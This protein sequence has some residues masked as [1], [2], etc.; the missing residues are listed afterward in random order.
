MQGYAMNVEKILQEV[1][2]NLN[3]V[4]QR[5]TPLGI[6]LWNTLLELHPADLADFFADIA[7]DQAH[8]LFADLPK[9]I[10]LEVFQEASDNL[11]TYFLSIMSDHEQ[12]DALHTL[13]VDELTD[14]FDYFSD[15]EL[16]IYLNLLHKRVR[17]KVLSLLQFDPESAGGI[18]T[19]D[20]FTLMEDYT[21]EKSI[22]ILQRLLP[23][24]DIHHQ[25]F[26]VD[27]SQRLLGHINLEDLVLRKPM[28]RIA[29]FMHKNELVA[30]TSDD[31]EKV[32]GRMVHYGLM[33]VPVIDEDNHFL[34]VIPSETLVDVIVEEANEDVQK[35][36]ALSP[37]KYPYFESSVLRLFYERGY[38]LI[39]LL[40]AE[41][42]SG[43]IIRA[44][45]ATLACRVILTSFIPMLIS[46]GG[47]TSNQS[48]AMVIQGMASG[49]I[50]M[51]NVFRFLRRESAVASLLSI[52]LG[53]T[54]FLR[55]FFMSSA[56]VESFIVGISLAFIVFL[57][58][59][60]GSAIPFLFK[61]FNID[62][63]FSAG[64]FLATIMDIIGVLIYCTICK[65]ILL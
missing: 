19:T 8:Y 4:I 46:A 30:R 31:R 27:K 45:E 25:I 1:K 48:S 59:L 56:L 12:A 63:A 20:V 17:D 15:E 28:D 21:V 23:S 36:A 13:S 62:P 54:A 16:K 22:H 44:Y 40:I 43:T 14:L 42:F 50:T 24:R 61:R 32:A 53:L 52:M 26:I 11:K 34:G 60:L 65:L 57:S 6:S 37:M 38:I 3:A 49:D 39:I 35:M 9:E 29:S 55:V 47:N 18:M 33:T 64:P 10:K 51:A 41:S 2:E 5:D 58:A 7:R